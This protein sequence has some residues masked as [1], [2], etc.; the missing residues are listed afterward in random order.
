MNMEK[1]SGKKIRLK[2]S[3]WKRKRSFV[4][5]DLGGWNSNRSP[6]KV[7]EGHM[8]PKVRQFTERTI[9]NYAA[10]RLGDH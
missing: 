8:C 6:D 4:G 2:G 3:R 1:D 5:K 7:W 10:R 9:V